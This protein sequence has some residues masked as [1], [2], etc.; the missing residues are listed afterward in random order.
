MHPRPA[1]PLQVPGQVVN[2]A[3]K[4]PS[5]HDSEAIV[6]QAE[7]GLLTKQREEVANEIRTAEREALSAREG[8]SSA[9]GELRELTAELDITRS[10]LTA[11][12]ECG[13]ACSLD[14]GLTRTTF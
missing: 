4:Q 13:A 2:P 5:A 7:V 1:K 8:L 9:Q 6:A 14:K 11:M 12:Q 3:C 10:R